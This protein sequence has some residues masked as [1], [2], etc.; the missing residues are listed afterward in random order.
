MDVGF[1]K[2]GGESLDCCGEREEHLS[3]YDVQ[4]FTAIMCKGESKHVNQGNTVKL[5]LK[6]NRQALS[7]VNIALTVLGIK[8]LNTINITLNLV[9]TPFFSTLVNNI[10]SL[11]LLSARQPVLQ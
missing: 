5:I 8:H 1:E 9:L 2:T 6:E 10:I 3:L 11:F 4:G 7:N